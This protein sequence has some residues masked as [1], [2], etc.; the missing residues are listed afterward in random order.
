MFIGME[1]GGGN[2]LVEINNRLNTWV[3]RGERELEDLAQYHT[4]IGLIL[5]LY[6]AALNKASRIKS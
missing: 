5:I 3:L 6:K 4:E 2:S 1:E